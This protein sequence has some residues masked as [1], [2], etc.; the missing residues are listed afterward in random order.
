MKSTLK[1]DLLGIAVILI[2]STC[3]TFIKIILDRTGDEVFQVIFTYNLVAALVCL[4]G[5]FLSGEVRQ[6]FRITKFLLALLLLNGFYDVLVTLAMF[7][8]ESPQYPVLANYLWPL[9]LTVFL[10]FKNKSHEKYAYIGAIVGFTGIA[11]LLMSSVESGISGN[12]I[13]LGLGFKAALFW[14]LYSALLNEGHRQIALFI[15]GAAQLISAVVAFGLIFVLSENPSWTVFQPVNFS[16]I[17]IFGIIHMSLAYV[18]WIKVVTGHADM[19]KFAPTTYLLPIL[20]I[21]WVSLIFQGT[22]TVWV[23]IALFMVLTGIWLSRRTPVPK[24]TKE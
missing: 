20:S 14:A 11:I 3:A 6:R 21:L 10:S 4:T 22:L 5:Y 23:L 17:A 15:Q 7:Y 1:F 13:G 9:L 8:S 2:W 12:L 24:K 18:L 19:R 16:L